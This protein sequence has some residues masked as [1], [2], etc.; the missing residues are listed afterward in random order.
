MTIEVLK[1]YAFVGALVYAG[2]VLVVL[3]LSA[4]RRDGRW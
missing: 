4:C 3:S 2:A 1:F